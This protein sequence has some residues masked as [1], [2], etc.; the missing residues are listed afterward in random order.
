[1]SHFEASSCLVEGLGIEEIGHGIEFFLFGGHVRQVQLN[2]FHVF[3]GGFLQHLVRQSQHMM[4]V[5]CRKG[6]KIVRCRDV[7][8]LQALQY[9]H[10]KKVIAVSEEFKQYLRDRFG[11]DDEELVQQRQLR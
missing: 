1:M 2:L 3:S 7:I 8:C 11:H 4:V 9:E 10:L 6:I 5:L